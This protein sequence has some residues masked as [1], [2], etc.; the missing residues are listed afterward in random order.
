[1]CISKKIAYGLIH[2]VAHL[3]V[4]R[5]E[6]TDGKN[7]GWKEGGEASPITQRLRAHA[8]RGD[9]VSRRGEEIHNLKKTMEYQL[10][11]PESKFWAICVVSH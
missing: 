6:E 8:A 1:M 9:R 2:A 7:P 11:Q 5:P 4:E 10:P 3:K